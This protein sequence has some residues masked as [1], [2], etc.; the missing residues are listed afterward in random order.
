MYGA[1]SYTMS[2]AGLETLTRYAEAEFT[3]KN[4][5]INS[6]SACPV[7]TN[8]MRYLKI[9]E[10]DIAYFNKNMKKNIP[11]GRIAEPDDIVKVIVF[12]SSK[13]SCKITGQI[14]KVDGGRSLTSLGYVHYKGM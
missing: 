8:S 13:R 6:I 11:L 4:L 9:S 7:N 5:K 2:K 3:S 10:S 12:L 14:I 1:I